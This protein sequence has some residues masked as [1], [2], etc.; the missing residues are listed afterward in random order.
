MTT[1]KNL[2][3]A[4]G[5][6]KPSAHAVLDGFGALSSAHPKDLKTSAR[7]S[8]SKALFYFKPH[9]R[10]GVQGKGNEKCTLVVRFILRNDGIQIEVKRG[11]KLHG[12]GQG[13]AKRRNAVFDRCK[14]I[15][16]P[17]VG[18]FQN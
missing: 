3:L 13:K 4:R 6:S 7:T 11:K 12:G 5:G 1:Q 2:V 10:A 9:A 14:K 16:P 8:N 18:G 15:L 17:S